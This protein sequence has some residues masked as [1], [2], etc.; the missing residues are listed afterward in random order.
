MKVLTLFI[1]FLMIACSQDGG[2]SNST[3]NILNNREL[4]KELE[5]ITKEQEIKNQVVT[6]K[7][8]LKASSHEL[9]AS[10]LEE[11]VSEGLLSEE[12]K[13]ELLVLVQ[14]ENQ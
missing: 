11:L 4:E 13:E 10:D 1:P 7:E 8:E 14:K 5:V 6:L 2:G 12:E 3:G 9:E